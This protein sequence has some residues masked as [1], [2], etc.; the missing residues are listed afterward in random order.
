M[1]VTVPEKNI[2]TW[3]N[4]KRFHEAQ[5]KNNTIYQK[6]ISKPAIEA[7]FLDLTTPTKK[8][9]LKKKGHWMWYVFPQI[10]GLGKSK[11]SI[12]YSI[13]NFK[14]G[15][16]YLEDPILKKN[17]LIMTQIILNLDNLDKIFGN[18]DYLKLRSS[19]TLFKLI[20]EKSNDDSIEL[21]TKAC[22]ITGTDIETIKILEKDPLYIK[23]SKLN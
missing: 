4:L 2:K 16:K 13:H 7:A 14:E 23:L 1:E 5:S 10:I 8:G 6:G 20:A 22:E 9:N 15:I 3:G 12:H 17:L 18:T 19:M 11:M 21:F